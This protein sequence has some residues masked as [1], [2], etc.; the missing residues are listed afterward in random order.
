MCLP[1]LPLYC[2]VA[3]FGIQSTLYQYTAQ[4][5]PSIS[6]DA[7]KI[8]VTQAASPVRTSAVISRNLHSSVYS[9]NPRPSPHHRD[10]QQAYCHYLHPQYQQQAE[11]SVKQQAA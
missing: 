5:C 9:H 1:N 4:A 8:P 7:P 3:S 2:S 11:E 6:L 10:Q